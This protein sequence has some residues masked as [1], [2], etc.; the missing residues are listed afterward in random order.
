MA[1]DKYI[2][3]ANVVGSSPRINLQCCGLKR[4]DI[5]ESEQNESLF[6]WWTN[7]LGCLKKEKGPII[8]GQG[9]CM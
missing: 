4:K 8:M 2:Y 6:C 5:V 1:L 3:L 9:E 7:I